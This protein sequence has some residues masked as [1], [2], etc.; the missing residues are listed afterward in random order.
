M[1]KVIG[2]EGISLK[3]YIDYL[4]G[5]FFDYVYLQQN[6]FDPVD[7]ATSQERQVYIYSFIYNI[8]ESDFNLADKENALHFFQQLRQLMRT[9]N[10]SQWNTGEFKR[11][12]EEISLLLEEKRER[13]KANA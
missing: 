9:W 1:M 7:E 11:L 13:V 8:L 4:K 5:E 3:D 6:A 2:E 12:E 10:S